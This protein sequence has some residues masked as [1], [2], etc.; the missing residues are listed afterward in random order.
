MTEKSKAEG[1]GEGKSGH[2]PKEHGDV[3]VG[4]RKEKAQG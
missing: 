3:G 4:D 1:A 2:L